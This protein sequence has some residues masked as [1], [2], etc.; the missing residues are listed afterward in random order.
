MKTKLKGLYIYLGILLIATG[1]LFGVLFAWAQQGEAYIPGQNSA[2]LSQDEKLEIEDDVDF[3]MFW[4]VWNIVKTKYVDSE[5][6]KN[7]D[8]YYGALEG[9]VNS[10]NDPYTIFLDPEASKMFTDELSGSFEGIG[11]EIG[12]RDGVLTVVSPLANSPAEIAGL[13]TGDR[14]FKVDGEES[15]DWSV[16]K[17]VEAI[18]GPKGETVVLTVAREGED[19]FI[20]ISIVR[21]KIELPSVKLEYKTIGDKKIALI[22]LFSFNQDTYLQFAEKLKEIKQDSEI[23]GLILDLRDD[24]GGYLDVAIDIASEWID[25]GVVVSE[26]SGDGY[27]FDYNSRSYGDLAE[28]PTVVLLNEGSASAAEIVAG[29]L[30]DYDQAVLVG[31]TSFGKGS[32]QTLQELADGSTIKITI[33][34]WLTPNGL[35]I[36][37]EGIDPDIFVDYT[38]EDWEAD[39][40]PQLDKALEIFTLSK[41]NL[42]AQ[43]DASQAEHKTG[44]EKFEELLDE[45]NTVEEETV[46]E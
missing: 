6:V 45:G 17:A 46:N 3:A 15:F 37:K 34:K 22:E 40:D 38:R 7:K 44:K 41:D 1:F 21:D 33:A 27:I 5:N 16:D 36:D 14:I 12:I 2:H 4:E 25:E 9:I 30:Q 31:D 10:L 11:A 35:N 8:L 29:A 18:R 43:I 39:R 24:P 23:D 26:K 20:D 13:K 19:D 28:M 42:Q 32:V